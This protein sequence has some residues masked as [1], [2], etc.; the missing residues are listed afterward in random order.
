M[1]FVC[2]Q[3]R[4]MQRQL[5]FTSAKKFSRSAEELK[6]RRNFKQAYNWPIPD[7]LHCFQIFRRIINAFNDS[8]A[9][10]TIFSG[11]CTIIDTKVG[12]LCWLKCHYDCD[13][14]T[15]PTYKSLGMK[16]WER[17]QCTISRHSFQTCY[18][19]W[20]SDDRHSKAPRLYF[21]STKAKPW[22]ELLNWTSRKT[23]MM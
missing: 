21:L 18:Y 4:E 14:K 8:D 1:L 3:N 11:L 20:H 17:R 7:P 9:I 12:R 22:R 10:L 2:F 23:F 19:K 6:G 15:Y 16:C 13:T 5:A